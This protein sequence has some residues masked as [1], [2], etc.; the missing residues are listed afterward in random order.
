MEQSGVESELIDLSDAS[1]DSCRS[2]D[3]GAIGVSMQRLISRIDDPMSS[4]GGY[5]PQRD[6]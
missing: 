1:L 4:M 3:A 2:L 6:E 5:N